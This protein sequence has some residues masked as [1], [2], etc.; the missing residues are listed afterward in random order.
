MYFVMLSEVET[1][2]NYFTEILHYAF[3]MTSIFNA[4]LLLEL[5]HCFFSLFLYVLHIFVHK[6]GA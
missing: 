5:L 3:M 4:I 6:L 2:Q 1:S